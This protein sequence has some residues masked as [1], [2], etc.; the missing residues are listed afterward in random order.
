MKM[1]NRTILIGA[2]LLVLPGL[3]Q[4]QQTPQAPAS[5]PATEKTPA[6]ADTAGTSTFAPTSRID[7]GFRG[8][9]LTGDPARFQRFRDER[10]GGYIPVFQFQRE[11]ETTFFRAEA[12]NVGYRD[13]RYAAEYQNIGKVK[14]GFEWNQ[15]PLFISSDIKTLYRDSGNGV[16]T[17]DRGLRQAIQDAGTGT[18]APAF[19]ALRNGVNT[20][21]QQFD[22]RSR[23]DIGR[24]NVA[25]SLNRD[26]DVKLNVKTTH[27]TGYNLMSFGFGTSPGLNPAVELGVPTDDRTTDVGGLLEFANTRGLFSVGFTGSSYDNHIPTVQFDNPLRATDSATLGPASGLTP[28]WPSNTAFAFNVNGSYK[29]PVRSRASAFISIGRWDQNER[30]VA[31]TVNTA[32]VAPPL[33][34]PNAETK[35][36]IVSMVYNFTSRPSEYV[37]LNAKYRYYDYANKTPIFEMPALVGDFSFNPATA[38]LWENEPA[39]FKRHTLDLE[40]SF[41]PYKYLGFGLGLTREDSDRTFRIFEKTAENSFRVTADSTGNQYVT[42]RAK[43]E[44]SRRTGSGFE[45]ELLDEVGE[46]S[47]TRHFDIADRDRDR[48]NLILTVTPVAQF[49]INASVSTGKDDYRNSGFGLR[50]NKNNA[51]SVGFDV[52]PV[53]TVSFGINYGF[54]KYTA[55]QWSRTANPAPSRAFDDPTREW[56]IDSADKV[57]T[58]T[59]SLD[60]LKALPKTDI[61]LS[62]D[63]SDGTATYVYQLPSN[64]TIL[65][66]INYGPH[67]GMATDA[68]NPIPVVQLPQ[69]NNKLSDARVDF[70]HYVRHNIALGV[71]YWYES[72]R[73]NDFALNASTSGAIVPANGTTGVFASTIYSGYLYRNYTA[74]T[75]FLRMSYLW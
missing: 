75:G 64:T 44:H 55:L 65:S 8:N 1:R 45:E 20:L 63:L 38:A 60:L 6:A 22:M 31:P 72:Y 13:Q 53:E 47:G 74:H 52:L 11:N 10:D 35:A 42:L 3:A 34:R 73:V 2:L 69:L 19:A 54:E 9:S 33:E 56:G 18:S 37:W 70:T 16:L 39:S 29:L 43:Y 23:R 57:K 4:A 30:L 7:F 40:A 25:Y 50:D 14:L 49:D 59:A 51:W 66:G 58:F 5:A 28:M 48:A 24:F 62:Y 32:L 21:A 12:N 61:R 26:V 27:R 68:Y 36:D 46:Q 15:I 17:I 67:D 71:G 41:S